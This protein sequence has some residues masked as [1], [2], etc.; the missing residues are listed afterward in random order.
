MSDRASS[1]SRKID[2]VMVGN[3]TDND[4]PEGLGRV[5]VSLPIREVENETDWVRI[6]TM[7]GG[8]GRG[9][10][11]VP[12][13]G[14]EVL[15]AFHLGEVRRPYVIGTLWNNQQTPP[16]V[17]DMGILTNNIRT[18]TSRAGHQLTFDDGLLWGKIILKA[19]RGQIIEIDDLLDTITIRDGGKVCEVK[20]GGI[21]P[22]S[23]VKI[24][25]GLSMATMTPKGII[26]IKG[27][28]ITIA[29]GKIALKAAGA[30]SIK[31]GGLLSLASTGIVKIKGAIV[32]IN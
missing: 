28:A 23:K 16:P 14:D 25:A 11:F 26:S 30:V 6:A 13:V 8:P 18:I 7:M 15:V 20:V 12:E 17:A 21:G 9:S 19:R 10:Y 31:S 27:K 4:D 32:K 24:R 5:K 3:V 29:A 1:S 22:F 2:G